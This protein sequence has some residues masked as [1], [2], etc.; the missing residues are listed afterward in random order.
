MENC[1]TVEEVCY[2]DFPTFDEI[3]LSYHMTCLLSAMSI[4]EGY[5]VVELNGDRF[6]VPD[7]AV[8]DVKVKMAAK[9]K[10]LE[11][12]GTRISD[13]VIMYL[14]AISGVLISNVTVL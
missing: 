4:L 7:Y 14:F 12:G 9:D 11:M 5:T 1:G 6:L 13:K 3:R 8:D 10:F 2:H